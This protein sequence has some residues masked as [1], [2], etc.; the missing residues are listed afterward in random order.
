MHFVQGMIMTD[1]EFRKTVKPFAFHKSNTND[2]Y[3]ILNKNN[4]ILK[5]GHH[6]SRKHVFATCFLSCTDMAWSPYR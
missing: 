3:I 4:V 2:C 6:I 5:F 1:K